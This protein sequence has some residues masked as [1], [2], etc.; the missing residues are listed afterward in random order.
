MTLVKF[1]IFYW[2]QSLSWSQNVTIEKDFGIDFKIS[3]RA[4]IPTMLCDR[5]LFENTS[6]KYQKERII[7]YKPPFKKSL[8]FA[9]LKWD[10]ILLGERIMSPG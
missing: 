5:F 7:V 6:G 3:L 9:I 10:V 8:I 2:T 1:L 4:F